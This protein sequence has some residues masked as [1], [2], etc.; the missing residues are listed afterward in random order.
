MRKTKYVILTYEYY[1][2]IKYWKTVTKF[3]SELYIQSLLTLVWERMIWKTSA[4]T[5]TKIF[6]FFLLTAVKCKFFS[7]LLFF[8]AQSS[9]TLANLTFKKYLKQSLFK[10]IKSPP[11]P[12]PLTCDYWYMFKSLDCGVFTLPTLLFSPEVIKQKVAMVPC[13]QIEHT[14]FSCSVITTLQAIQEITL[15]D[16]IFENNF[17]TCFLSH[18]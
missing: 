8:L 10:I 4:Q 9:K 7:I 3:T 18:I 2:C 5:S 13:W 1:I 15:E 11:F 16:M 6:F 14:P 12:S 17:Y